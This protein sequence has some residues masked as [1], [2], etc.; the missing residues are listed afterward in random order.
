MKC[1]W[2]VNSFVYTNCNKWNASKLHKKQHTYNIGQSTD[3]DTETL[4]YYFLQTILCIQ[5][6][7][8]F[9]I[10]FCFFSYLHLN[11]LNFRKSSQKKVFEFFK[12]EE[13]KTLGNPNIIF[14]N[15]IPFCFIRA[16]YL[17]YRAEIHM[18][19]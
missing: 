4:F 7:V 3:H 8:G 6:H 12:T 2:N 18:Y 9:N 19:F 10:P 14:R 1:M 15:L 11:A 17:F 5:K 13:N 16:V